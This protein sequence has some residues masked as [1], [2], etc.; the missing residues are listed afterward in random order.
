MNFLKLAT[1]TFFLSTIGACSSGEFADANSISSIASSS[2]NTENKNVVKDE[3]AKKQERTSLEETIPSKEFEIEEPESIHQDQEDDSVATPV[4]TTG[5]YLIKCEEVIKNKLFC[6]VVNKT[7]NSLMEDISSIEW[8]VYQ[9]EILLSPEQ[10]IVEQIENEDSWQIEIT[11]S[12]EGEWQLKPIDKQQATDKNYQII[13]D[14]PKNQ[15]VNELTADVTTID[16]G[17]ID[18]TPQ[19]SEKPTSE[20]QVDTQQASAYD[21]PLNY[22]LSLDATDRKGIENN[23]TSF[24][25]GSK[26]IIHDLHHDFSRGYTLIIWAKTTGVGSEH[27]RLLSLVGESEIYIKWDHERQRYAGGISCTGEIDQEY[28]EWV[29][30]GTGT[31]DGLWHHL[32]LTYDGDLLTFYFDGI[33]SGSLVITKCKN[34]TQNSF[35]IINAKES[36][37]GFLDDAKVYDM[38][39]DP[40]K[41]LGKFNASKAKNPVE[42]P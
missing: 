40:N 30:S 29:D 34:K 22:Y 20:V 27:P 8:D 31:I 10:I 21:F 11:V 18:Q 3:D 42:N 38:A 16:G 7:T 23:A 39:L 32:A 9:G 14:K 41:I 26:S 28:S 13:I 6:K 5:A 4:M 19:D 33:R 1:S 24:T 35:A 15:A 2:S 17:S 12:V 37:D 25:V 36:Y